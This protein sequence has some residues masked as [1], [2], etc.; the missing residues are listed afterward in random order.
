VE[1]K[2]GGSKPHKLGIPLGWVV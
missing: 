2:R 1:E